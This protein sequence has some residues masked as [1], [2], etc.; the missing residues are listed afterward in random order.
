MFYSTELYAELRRLRE[1]ARR[2]GHDRKTVRKDISTASF[3]APAA[4][5]VHVG[6]LH[7]VPG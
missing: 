1:V 2:T 6:L 7:A 5:S 4:A 3:Q